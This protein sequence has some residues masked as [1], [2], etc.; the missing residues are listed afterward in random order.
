MYVNIDPQF[1]F[2][3]TSYVWLTYA[4]TFAPVVKQVLV[5]VVVL[6]KT[7]GGGC[8]KN[9][10]P[11][12]FSGKRFCSK[13]VEKNDVLAV[14]FDAYDSSGENVDACNNLQDLDMELKLTNIEVVEPE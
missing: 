7:S 14:Y 12:V 11:G 5:D 8:F 3:G 9:V 2:G 6:D 4:A 1:Q 10:P 13:D